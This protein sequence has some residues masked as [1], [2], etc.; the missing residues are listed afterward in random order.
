LAKHKHP[1]KLSYF[2]F[3]IET[4]TK[5]MGKSNVEFEQVIER[6][7]GLDVHRIEKAA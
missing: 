5:Y 1:G 3:G 2:A 6:E 4:N 7:C